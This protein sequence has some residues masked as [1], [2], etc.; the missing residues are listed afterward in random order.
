M[1]DREAL[2]EQAKRWSED[3][4]SPLWPGLTESD[5]SGLA[6]PLAVELEAVI[7]ERDSARAA[8]AN[9][10][11]TVDL[12]VSDDVGMPE[13]ADAMD[14]AFAVLYPMPVDS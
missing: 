13:F 11:D 10:R 5:W 9:L 1:S 3:L 12:Y 4:A 2:I 14:Q 7:G 6:F 8:L